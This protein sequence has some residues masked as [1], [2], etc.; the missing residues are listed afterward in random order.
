M[1]HMKASS[2]ALSLIFEHSAENQSKEGGITKN[3]EFS[4]FLYSYFVIFTGE[5]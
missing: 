5:Y 2:E 3:A 4:T 1:E